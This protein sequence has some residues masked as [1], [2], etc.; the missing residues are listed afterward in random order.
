MPGAAEPG[1]HV[2]PLQTRHPGAAVPIAGIF[3]ES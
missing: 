2:R 1:F 3:T